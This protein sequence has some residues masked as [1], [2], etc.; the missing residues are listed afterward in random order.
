[1][2]HFLLESAKLDNYATYQADGKT[3]KT[4]VDLDANGNVVQTNNYDING[5][6]I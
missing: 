5:K 3:L 2:E 6:L 4:W 1:V